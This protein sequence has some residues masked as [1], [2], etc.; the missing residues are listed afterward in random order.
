MNT[1]IEA[2]KSRPRRLFVERKPGFTTEAK[3]QKQEIERI[4][5]EAE[6]F[7]TSL[8]V[9]L[10]VIYDIFGLTDEEFEWVKE[11]IFVD[12]RTDISY[13]SLSEIGYDPYGNSIPSFVTSEFLPGQFDARADAAE[14]C[15]TLKGVDNQDL[16]IRTG[17]LI[18]FDRSLTTQELELIN[19]NL[20]NPVVERAKDLG[21][22]EKPVHPEPEG[23]IVVE[24]F[25]TMNIE[26]LNAFRIS[27]GLGLSKADMEF[28]QDYFINIEKRDPTET[29]LKFIDTYWSDHCR[30]GTFE[31]ILEDI[32]FPQSPYG[33]TLEQVFE[34][35]LQDR[36]VIHGDNL[37]NKPVTL[38][39]IATINTK[40]LIH[41]G[42]LDDLEISEEINACSI[43]VEVEIDD[44][45]EI[46]IIPFK[47]ESHNHPTTIGPFGGA[48][49]C[50]G[51]CVRDILASR[52]FPFMA[53]RIS[54]CGDP[55]ESFYD[56]HIGKLS[57]RYIAQLAAQGNASYGNQVGVPTPLTMEFYH[58]G[59]K[60]K[61]LELGFVAGAVR[62]SEV[63]REEPVAGDK[64]LVIGGRTGRDGIGGAVGSSQEHNTT[65]IS[66]CGAEVQ[67]G[68]PLIEQDI[69]RFFHDP[70]VIGLIKRCNDF[71]AGGVGIAIG[72]LADGLIIDLD[73]VK[74]KYSGLNPTEI[75]IS[76]SQ[77]RMAVLMSP[78]DV[79]IFQALCIK[80]N[81]ESSIAAEVTDQERLII[82]Y[83]GEDAVNISRDFLKTNGV[84]G[85][86][87]VSIPDISSR[88]EQ[89]ELTTKEDILNTFA[90]L[91]VALKPG[92][93]DIFDPSILGG[94][95][96]LPL[97][98]RRQ[99]TPA[100]GAINLIPVTNGITNTA[101]VVGVG[102]DPYVSKWSPFYGAQYGVI[103]AITKV[104]AM[105]GDWTKLRLT[106]QEYFPK[107]GA[108]SEKWGQPVASL[109][110]IYGILDQLGLPAIGG[111]DS[112]SGTFKTE[113]GQEI[114]VPS[115][116]I[117]FAVGTMDAR[118]AISSELKESGNNIY[119]LKHSPLSDGGPDIGQII[120][121]LKLLASF[122]KQKSIVSAATVEAG[123]LASKLAKMTLGNEI[124]VNINY[125]G[126][127]LDSNY[128]SIIIES[129]HE[130][131]GDNLIHIGIT[132]DEPILNLNTIDLSLSEAESA[133]LG[134]FAEVYPRSFQSSQP[135]AEIPYHYAEMSERVKPPSPNLQ[136]TMLLLPGTNCAMETSR[137]FGPE[138]RVNQMIFKNLT[139]T[140]IQ[141]SVLELTR[142]LGQSKIFV[143]PGGF[144]AGD[145]PDGSAKF[146]AAVLQ[147]T[148]IK[149]AIEKF[150]AA[151][152]L[153]LGICNGFQA[154]I[155]AGYFD[156]D[157][158]N[159]IKTATL[160]HNESAQ[161]ATGMVHTQIISNLSPW[162]AE[163]KPG[164]IHSVPI[165]HG[166]GRLMLSPQEY[167]IMAK[168]G[169]IT[170][171]YVSFN[172]NLITSANPNGSAY[173][174]EGLTDKTGRILGKMGHSER[175]V[176]QPTL[177]I[178]YPHNSPQNIFAN[179]LRY[180]E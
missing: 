151:D 46:W 128:G 45:I 123:G 56:T 133:L 174:I 120:Q 177:A 83:K 136:T 19:T 92:Q 143:L 23:I 31:T 15:I 102:F 10:F 165:S 139:P 43:Y 7:S 172:G 64:V 78:Q 156:V 179:G 1:T 70:E 65:S 170:T 104:A 66:S 115:T 114:N 34:Q 21:I 141:D 121:N 160:T 132:T 108:D 157:D 76:E 85:R 153:I 32:E 126:N 39:D 88:P 8:A 146:Y 125:N 158:A 124:G 29:E 131:Q 93:A 71:G 20:I 162:L 173:G 155:K 53:A 148:M 147:N 168:N 142:L 89:S 150:L 49:T 58:P 90:S 60:A 22:L 72:E 144:S 138:A 137:A 107:L 2:K 42:L 145:E 178:N 18:A 59:Y 113:S 86:Q 16:T 61:H 26:E 95:V 169:Q 171:Q 41:E 9:R 30:H 52:S 47:N 13:N 175:T 82:H 74:L 75:T 81:L 161:H 130:L 4:L 84:R 54:G 17:T 122:N 127:L 55:T 36:A 129:A 40:K 57:Q 176:G 103:Q 69:I 91:N 152:G 27:F 50:V 79:E 159:I 80:Y 106:L 112:M 110:G 140:M 167:E 100:E 98:G 149:T 101:C 35:Y 73:Q 25:V 11:G 94:T 28:V 135:I 97:G 63:R 134:T 166:E 117:T 3:K 154:L 99:L 48:A 96:M 67:N 6:N 111:K 12:P 164:T 14:Q 37:A 87:T 68:N 180:F 51:G 163:Y 118:D 44:R 119:V 38:M 105:G 77:E 62:A 5:L 109:L 24:D 116:T 33:D